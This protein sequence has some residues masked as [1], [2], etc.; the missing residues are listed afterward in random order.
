MTDGVCLPCIYQVLIVLMCIGQV[1]R[2]T[3]DPIIILESL[4]GNVVCSSD[5]GF[6]L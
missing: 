3:Q 6:L 5:S 1:K 4:R 2:L